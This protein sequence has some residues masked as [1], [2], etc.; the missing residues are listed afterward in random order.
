MR[1]IEI[2]GV[3]LVTIDGPPRL[4]YRYKTKNN[5]SALV[6]ADSVEAVGDIWSMSYWHP[7]SGEYKEAVDDLVVP[8]DRPVSLEDSKSPT[9][10]LS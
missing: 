5:A 10:Q 9:E 1:D 2:I 4:F 8:L 6:S 3:E 7:A